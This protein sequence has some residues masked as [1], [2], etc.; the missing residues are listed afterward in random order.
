VTLYMLDT[1]IAS[2]VIRGDL[3]AIRQRL[4]MAPIESLVISSVT[5]AEL[6]YGVAKR[7]YPK[8]LTQAVQLFLERVETLPW[9][10]DVAAAY[11]DLRARTESAGSPL[12]AL[13]MMI[14]SHAKAADAILV[15][16][17][18]AFKA[19]AL[20]LKLEDWSQDTH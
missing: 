6:R 20:E 15:T 8:A 7:G 10:S 17:D 2:H 13:D 19:K 3:P 14:A 12:A 5:E 18:K 4:L 16:R 9:S 1:N 11:A